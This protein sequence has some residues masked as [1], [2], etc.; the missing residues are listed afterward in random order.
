MI[1]RT[2]K[3]GLLAA[4]AVLALL[5]TA[6][7]ATAADATT[8][9]PVPGAVVQ[10][11]AHHRAH[12]THRFHHRTHLRRHHTRRVH[13]LAPRG[14]AYRSLPRTSAYRFAAFT[15]PYR[16]QYRLVA[17]WVP[18]RH[19]VPTNGRVTT[20]Y[21]R[22]N[23]R[24]G[25]GTGYRVIGHRHP[26]RRLALACRTRGSSVHGNRTWYRLSHHRGYVSA[27]YVRADRALPWC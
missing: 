17:Q 4:V 9:H 11:D 24:S 25:P 3:S 19:V 2:F 10:Y 21:L 15:A 12:I 7:G 1:R 26:G 27:R 14:V 6:A 18:Y 16:L 20:R 22:L 5:P 13:R 8:Q 23:V